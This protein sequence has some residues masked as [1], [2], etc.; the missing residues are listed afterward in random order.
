MWR[1]YTLVFNFDHQ[2]EV[3]HFHIAHKWVT[4]VHLTKVFIYTPTLPLPVDKTS[5]IYVNMVKPHKTTSN[6][7]NIMHGNIVNLKLVR[8]ANWNQSIFKPKV[9]FIIG[10]KVMKI[11]RLKPGKI[12]DF[13][14]IKFGF[15][16]SSTILGINIFFYSPQNASYV[17]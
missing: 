4:Y 15:V 9:L 7:I 14:E 17:N 6:P 3:L 13:A 16:Y 10:E 11:H 5:L 2:R 1:N 12:F 8:V